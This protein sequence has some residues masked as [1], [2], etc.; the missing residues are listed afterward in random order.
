MHNVSNKR[1]NVKVIE[2]AYKTL[3]TRFIVQV[4]SNLENLAFNTWVQEISAN[5]NQFYFTI[6]CRK[7]TNS[8]KIEII[9]G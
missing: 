8:I 1:K 3:N 4:N 7:H 9:D 2:F 6:Y 5:N